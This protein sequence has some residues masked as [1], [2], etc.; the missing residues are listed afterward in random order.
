M[1]PQLHMLLFDLRQRCA[2]LL[3]GVKGLSSLP[4][5]A[6]PCA[7]WTQRVLERALGQL[8]GLLAD[9]GIRV[10][11]LARNYLHH[12]KRL[13]ELAR[14][15][16]WGPVLALERYSPQDRLIT[17]TTH[18]ICGE[19]GYPAEP[20]LCV[21]LSS[22]HYW[23]SPGTNLIFVPASE[24]FHLLGLSD[25]Y[26]ELGHILL[27]R[28]RDTLVAPFLPAI[29]RYYQAE[30]VRARRDGMAEGYHRELDIH[31]QRWRRHWILE[32]EADM[33]AA[34]LAGPAYGW[35]NIRL[36]VNLVDDVFNVDQEAGATHPAD[37]A[38]TTAIELVLQATGSVREA[39]E[40]RSMWDEFASMT[41]AQRPLEFSIRFPAALLGELS[42]FLIPRCQQL[43]LVR[44][45]EQ[46]PLETG[47][48]V[49]RLLGEA[50]R[51][52]R[53]D[54]AAFAAWERRQIASLRADLG[55]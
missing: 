38:R 55:V 3:D 30:H 4:P 28:H 9:P 41:G 10:P 8:D 25:L 54:P 40:I 24:P 2:H 26:H 53:G 51:Q 23:T 6:Q 14:A 20:P 11:E 19:I 7:D 39:A 27:L 49:T 46:R 31:R 45:V 37:D 48:N 29:D 43:G 5:E 36:C 35:S 1:G 50:W 42:E 22:R 34:Y 52:F 15:T 12:Y 47:M 13:A 21:A 18:R 32:F 16:E 17:A 33:L 44:H